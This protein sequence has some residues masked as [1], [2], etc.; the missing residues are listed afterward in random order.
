MRR[1]ASG[2]S[3]RAGASQTR[4]SDPNSKRRVFEREALVH[5]DR[6]YAFALRL[7]GGNEATAEDLVQDA[8]LRAY[9]A[10]HQYKAGTNC[11]AWLLTILRNSYLNQQRREG[12]LPVSIPGTAG[13]VD[14][15][16]DFFS[17]I[18]DEPLMRA[19]DALPLPYREAV[20]LSDIEG[21]GYREVAEILAVPVGTVKSR[22]FRGRRSLRSRLR[23]YAAEFGYRRTAAA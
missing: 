9:R 5:L 18:I 2:R 14:P 12:R 15:E 1:V 19:I 16:R 3:R 21:L 22:I 8:I 6:L 17:H 7:T 4:R 10:W 20:V 11:R 23:D 13:P